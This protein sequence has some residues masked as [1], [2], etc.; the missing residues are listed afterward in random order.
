MQR[1][2]IVISVICILF[3]VFNTSRSYGQWSQASGLPLTE[4]ADEFTVIGNRI[5]VNVFSAAVYTSTDNGATWL[6]NLDHPGISSLAVN[7]NN[8]YAGSYQLGFFRSSNSGAM[9]EQVSS[10]NYFFNSLAVNQ[11]YIFAGMFLNIPNQNYIFRSSNN[12]T[13]WQQTPIQRDAYCIK[14]NG[15]NIFAGTSGNG[16]YLSTNNGTNWL[17]T[18]LDT[19]TVGSLAFVGNNVFAGVTDY[20][21]GIGGIYVSSN[22]GAGWSRIF[23]DNSYGF[24]ISAIGTVLFAGSSNGIFV[25]TNNGINW[26]QKNEGLPNPLP[27]INNFVISGNFVLVSTSK[28]VWRRAA[29]ELIGIEPISTE[30][31]EEFR[32]YQNYPNPFN[33]ET[34][35][36]FNIQKAGFVTLKI[37][38]Y[39]GKEISVTVNQTL[40]PGI[41]E[42]PFNATGLSSGVYFYKLTTKE[43]TE[44]KKLMVI[45]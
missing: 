27:I 3:S 41:Y 13:N 39:L 37:Y 34:K 5:F 22:N 1:Y 19:G 28:S 40:Q 36:K 15:N 17:Q 4:T 45:K 38:D 43:F 30:V 21:S 44:T 14:I 9:W 29:G 26:Q 10:N 23:S 32:L 6:S 42:V 24:N 25:S 8:I 18:S 7:G 16:V 12:G 11:G 2:I 31:P 20:P 33:P 35:I